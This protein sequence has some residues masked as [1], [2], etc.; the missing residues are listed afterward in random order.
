MRSKLV[1]VGKPDYIAH[2]EESG[3]ETKLARVAEVVYG[4]LSLT[5]AIRFGHRYKTRSVLYL[6][7]GEGHEIMILMKA[8]GLPFTSLRRNLPQSKKVGQSK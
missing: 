4:H 6:W 3:D 1:G 2:W 7:F 8:K 5:S